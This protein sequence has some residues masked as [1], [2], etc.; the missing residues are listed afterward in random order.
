MISKLDNI[1]RKSYYLFSN[2]TFQF[3]KQFR[4]AIITLALK[5]PN[6]SERE[7]TIAAKNFLI[8]LIDNENLPQMFPELK[9]DS[10]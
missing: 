5:L 6:T 4:Q 8:S 1:M 10:Y 3:I 7:D 2:E 9:I